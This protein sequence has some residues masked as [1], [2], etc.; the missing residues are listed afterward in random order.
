MMDGDGDGIRGRD[1]QLT[2][3]LNLQV[4]ANFF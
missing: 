2:F 3:R 4:R 1:Q